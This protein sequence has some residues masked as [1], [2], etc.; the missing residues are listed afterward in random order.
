V[1]GLS[2]L[3]GEQD[4]ARGIEL[5]AMATR[6]LDASEDDST[7]DYGSV[8]LY[9][10]AGVRRVFAALRAK[11][12]GLRP[13]TGG[14]WSSIVAGG[15]AALYVKPSDTRTWELSAEYSGGWRETVPLQLSLGQKGGGPRGYERSNLPAARRVVGLLEERRAIGAFGRYAHWGLAVFADGARGWSGT[16]PFGD[17]YNLR[18]SVGA[19]LLLAVPAQSRRLLRVDLAI[20]TTGDARDSWRVSVYV[21]DFTRVFWREPG[22]LARSRAVSLPAAM[23]GWP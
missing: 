12:E 14:P 20:P 16:V 8:D 17:D 4:F 15:R 11:V 6:G 23:F 19:G 22:D 2:S 10:G 3:R 21:R 9:L 13:Q 1:T 7:T 5:A 18:A